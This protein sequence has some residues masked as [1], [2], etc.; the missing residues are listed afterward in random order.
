MSVDGDTA[1]STCYLHAQHV[2][3]GTAGGDQFVFAGRYLD[4]LVRT[5]D[6]W[7]IAERTLEAMWTS[8]NPAVIARPLQTLGK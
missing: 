2:L 5:A 7:R 6:G 3:P 4:N 8:G 1:T